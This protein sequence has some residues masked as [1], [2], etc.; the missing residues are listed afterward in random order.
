MVGLQLLGPDSA[1]LHV[2]SRA[3]DGLLLCEAATGRV[4]LPTDVGSCDCPFLDSHFLGIFLNSG[5][6]GTRWW[7]TNVLTQIGLGYTFLFLLCGRKL[8]TQSLVAGGVLIG[9]WLLF[10][11]YPSSGIDLQKG[12]PEVGVSAEWAQEHLEG[13]DPSWHKNANAAHAFDTWL[14]NLMPERAP[15]TGKDSEQI[16]RPFT[17]NPGG[18]QTLSFLPSLA[19]MLFGLMCGELLRSKRSGSEK[20]KWMLVAGVAGLGLGWLLGVTGVSPVVKRIWTPSWT[21]LSTGW[22]ILILATLYWIIDIKGYQR[23]T[24]PLVVVGMNSIAVYSMEMLLRPWMAETLNIHLGDQL[25]LVAG[26]A[27]QPIAQS[28]LVG[29]SFWVICGWMYRQK[30]FVRI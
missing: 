29:L 13:V 28:T 21:L 17:A 23:W 1:V 12:A 6:P 24:F 18:Y 26:P 15:F 20:L 10:V 8:K 27:F 22:C 3:I 19:T 14:L 25:F 9:T 5:G 16:R 4:L 2:Y 30:L 11:L 7:F